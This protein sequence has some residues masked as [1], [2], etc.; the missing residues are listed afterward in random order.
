MYSAAA[1]N[2]VKFTD[3]RMEP[4]LVSGI[5]ILEQRRPR[6]AALNVFVPRAAETG[7]SLNSL[8][9][10]HAPQ[11]GHLPYHFGLSYPQ[12][13]HRKT[14]FCFIFPPLHSALAA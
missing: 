4:A 9:V 10:F 8:M 1:E 3:A 6:F 11:D 12:S 7:F 13:P 14:V 2:A 5:N